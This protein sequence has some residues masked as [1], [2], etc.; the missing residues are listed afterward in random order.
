[1]RILHVNHGYPMRYNAGSEV[2]ARNLA[3]A[4]VREGHEVAVFAREENPHRPEYALHVEQDGSI[5]VH[6]V[7]LPRTWQRFA[8]ASV[9]AVFGDLVRTFEPGA[10]HLH[11]LNHLSIGLPEVA[12]R[13]G[14]VVVY[15]VHDFWLPCPRGQFIRWSMGAE[16]WPLCDEQ[17][18][19]RC[20]RECFGRA[21]TGLAERHDEDM[22]YWSGWVHARMNAVQRQLAFIDCFACPSQTVAD[23]LVHRFPEVAD[24]VVRRDYG[25]PVAPRSLRKDGGPFTIGFLGTHTAPKGVDQ[26][27]RAFATLRGDVRLQVWGRARGQATEALRQLAEPMKDR[28]SFPGE[29]VNGSIFDA[30]MPGIDVVVVPSIWLENSPLVI[31]E[32]QQARVCVVTADAGGMAEYVQDGVNGLLFRHRD[33]QDLARVLQRLVDEPG[34]AA[35]LG[36]R[37]YLGTPDGRV[38]TMAEDAAFLADLYARL[39]ARRER[40]VLP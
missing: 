5:D 28:V 20:A 17:Q 37:G 18:D 7:N 4:H 36:S 9:D 26:L 39:G 2:Y 32:A 15:T 34:L 23:A 33:E 25:F 12:H 14:A 40:R 6:L 22:R 24:R 38:P 11:H 30:V 13:C 35:S 29:Y 31:H 10:V 16:P 3:Q 8:D 27:V 19:A 1:M 21:F